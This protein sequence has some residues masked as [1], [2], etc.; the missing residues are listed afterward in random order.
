MMYLRY[1]NKTK[2]EVERCSVLA[3]TFTNWKTNTNPELIELLNDLFVCE[4]LWFLYIYC[5][6]NYCKW[7][8][9]AL[10]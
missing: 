9:S 1:H 4:S 10:V 7:C 5:F 3:F 2:K 6:L 8:K